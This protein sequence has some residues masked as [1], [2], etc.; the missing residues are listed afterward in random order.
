[1]SLRTILKGAGLAPALILSLT[2]TGASADS[3]RES[4]ALA[5]LV[6]AGELP[7]VAQRLPEQPRV[8]EADTIGRHGGDLRISMARAKDTRMMTVY[9]YARLV[10]YDRKYNLVSDILESFDIEDARIFTL[11]L[12][13]GHKW[14]DGH[15]FTTEDFRYWWEDVA[16][17]TDL[18]PLGPPIFM[19]VDGQVPTVEI[20]DEHTIRYTWQKPNP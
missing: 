19:K 20:I 7:P 16:N 5:K 12:R 1:M 9:G 17:N 6:S 3:F 8:V 4:P 11:R 14:S 15:P 13:K 10:G 18:A 2:A